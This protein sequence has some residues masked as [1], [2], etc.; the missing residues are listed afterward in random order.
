MNLIKKQTVH[1][2]SYLSHNDEDEVCY[3]SWGSVPTRYG[4]SRNWLWQFRSKTP[5]LFQFQ[6]VFFVEFTKLVENVSV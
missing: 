6:F 4:R 3:R 2:L 5:T 1:I